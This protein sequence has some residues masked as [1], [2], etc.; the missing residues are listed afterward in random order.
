M[1]L[2]VVSV[3]TTIQFFGAFNFARYIIAF[4]GKPQTK[5]EFCGL[6]VAATLWP[7]LWPII[8]YLRW[9]R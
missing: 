1:I 5:L 8:A 7:I 2:F 4:E 9:T 6:V 3:L